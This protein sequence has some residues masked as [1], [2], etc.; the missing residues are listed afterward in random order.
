MKV[1]TQFYCIQEKKTYKIGS[2]YKGKRQ[3]LGSFLEASKP[4][5]KSKQK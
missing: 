3:D 5:K 1:T 4:K 2:E